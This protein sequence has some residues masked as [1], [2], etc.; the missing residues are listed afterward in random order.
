[1]E[2]QPGD[3][4]FKFMAMNGSVGEVYNV[5]DYYCY[6]VHYTKVIY[7][8]SLKKNSLSIG[9]IGCYQVIVNWYSVQF[10]FI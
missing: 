4:N 9:N 8:H 7:R 5:I 1:M 2:G 3:V 10:H 6:F